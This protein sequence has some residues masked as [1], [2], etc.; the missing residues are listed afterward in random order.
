MFFLG[1]GGGGC[2]DRNPQYNEA[3]RQVYQLFG[4]LMQHAMTF[5]SYILSNLLFML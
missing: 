4:R 2:Y 5:S 3:C 1:G